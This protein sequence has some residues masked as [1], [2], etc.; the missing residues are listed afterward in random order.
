MEALALCEPFTTF[1]I[2]LHAAPA[3]EAD[4]RTRLRHSSRPPGGQI[5]TTI[6]RERYDD[7]DGF[8]APPLMSSRTIR[9]HRVK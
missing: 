8:R 3:F 4:Q 5:D 2:S 9:I 6:R 7:C 1:P